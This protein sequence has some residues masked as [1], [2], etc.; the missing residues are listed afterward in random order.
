MGLGSSHSHTLGAHL[1]PALQEL[2]ARPA[3]K[4]NNFAPTGGHMN[5]VG[6]WLGTRSLENGWEHNEHGYGEA[7]GAPFSEATPIDWIFNVLICCPRTT[8]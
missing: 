6:E 2:Q 3:T 7:G 1:D 8:Y 5:T 4:M